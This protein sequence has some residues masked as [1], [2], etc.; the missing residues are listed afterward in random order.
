[1][2]TSSILELTFKSECS[3]KSYNE[4]TLSIRNFSS[5][6]DLSGRISILRVS[7]SSGLKN[8][9]MAVRVS[10]ALWGLAIRTSADLLIVIC[11]GEKSESILWE[12]NED[13][14]YLIVVRSRRCWLW[15]TN[16][17]LM[18]FRFGF[19]EKCSLKPQRSAPSSENNSQVSR[20]LEL[21]SRDLK[22]WKTC[23]AISSPSL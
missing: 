20:R 12:L 22:C 17:A 6:V 8:S 2:S 9:W 5:G 23:P 10:A 7:W 18:C 16:V 1:M 13:S 14:W 11:C 21:K 15:S 4:L 3:G 19:R